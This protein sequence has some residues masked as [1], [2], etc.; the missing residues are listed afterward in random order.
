MPPVARSS[1]SVTANTTA[2]SA[3]APL[4]MKCF[5]PFSTHESPSWTAVAAM[6]CASDPAP[7]SVSAKHIVVS[8]R[9][10]G[11]TYFSR[12]CSGRSMRMGFGAAGL[13]GPSPN[14][15][16]CSPDAAPAS[17]SSV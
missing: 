4:V 13:G 5:V 8:P 7:G 3:C 15:A 2:T 10:S 6:A 14:D 17:T 9:T 12:R 11:G 16:N 1:R